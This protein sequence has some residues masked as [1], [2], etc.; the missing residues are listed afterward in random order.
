MDDLAP[1]EAYLAELPEPQQA[2]LR[3]VRA[4]IRETCPN[5]TEGLY[6]RMPGFRLRG[7]LLL[8]YA[9]FK[10]HCA[11]YPASGMV[12]EAL[13]DDL[14]PYLTEKATIRF[15]ADQPIPDALVRRIVEVRVAEGTGPKGGR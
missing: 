9:G 1:I 8:S 10:K 13:G 12:Q 15:T 7:K 11:L 3:R 5:A 2:V 14:A 4:V 6:Y